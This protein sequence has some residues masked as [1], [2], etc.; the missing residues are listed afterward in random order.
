MLGAAA[1]LGSGAVAAPATALAEPTDYGY[2]GAVGTYTVPAGVTTIRIEATGGAGGNGGDSHT[3]EN[4]GEAGGKGGSGGTVSAYFSVT[5]GEQLSYYVGG[6]G[7]S[8]AASTGFGASAT[9]GEFGGGAGGT[10]NQSLSETSATG[11]GG[12]GGAATWVKTSSGTVLAV[13]GGGGGGGGGGQADTQVNGSAAFVQVYGGAGGAGGL[14]PA[15]G[16]STSYSDQY[17]LVQDGAVGGR[18]GANSDRSG[19]T[20]GAAV[21]AQGG[22]GGG[23]GGGYENCGV[24]LTGGGAPGA[25]GFRSDDRHAQ[26]GGAGGGGG[27]SCASPAATGVSYSTASQAPGDAGTVSF[28][29]PQATTTALTSSAPGGAQDF[30]PTFTAT[31]SPN[32][33]S[34]TVAF[35]MIDSAGTRTTLCGASPVGAGGLATCTPSGA[36]FTTIGDYGITAAYSG[37]AG[38]QTSTSSQLP[39][40]V[41]QL[42]ETDFV[43]PP[44]TL[45]RYQTGDFTVQVIGGEPGGRVTFSSA[46]IPSRV[47]YLDNS[48]HATTQLA[49]ATSGQRTVTASYAPVHAT[50]NTSAPSSATATV[51]VT[52]EIAGPHLEFVPDSPR[53]QFGQSQRI[54]VEKHTP[55]LGTD[56]VTDASDFV[57]MTMDGGSCVKSYVYVN[58]EPQSAFWTCTPSSIGPH[59]VT[60]TDKDKDYVCAGT[61]DC[62]EYYA[63]ASTTLTALGPAD[64]LRI[65]AAQSSVEVGEPD[66]VTAHWYDAGGDDLGP[67]TGVTYTVDPEGTCFATACIPEA[68]GKHTVT[69]TATLPG[70]GTVSARTTFGTLVHP[71]DSSP[72]PTSITID[73]PGAVS[74]GQAVTYVAHM[75]TDPRSHI[76]DVN[77]YWLVDG[78]QAQCEYLY[79]IAEDV[80]CELTIGSGGT[81]AISVVYPA[82]GD[83]AGSADTIFVPV[84]GPQVGIRVSPSTASTT[85]G[86][87]VTFTVDAV[88]AFGDVLGPATGATLSLPDGTGS[89]SG[90]ACTPTSAGS[91][92]VTAASSAGYTDT[93]TLNVSAGDLSYVTVTPS[94]STISAGAPQTYAVAGFD[95]FGNRVDA[96]APTL[97]IDGARASCQAATC[98]ATGSGEHTVTAALGGLHAFA[99]LTVQ[100]GPLNHLV[101]S[102]GTATVTAGG[103]QAYTAEGFDQFGNDLGPETGSAIFSLAGGSCTGDTCTAGLAGRQTVTASVGGASGTASLTVQPGP[104]DHL[105]VS[106]GT[107]TVT[108]GSS[109]AY[110]AE[111]FDAFGNSLGDETGSASFSISPDGWCT[112][113]ICT[114]N[115]DGQHTVS[116]AVG[117]ASGTAS[118]TVQPGA[119]GY[120]VASPG[121]GSMTA[122]DST[123]FS[124]EGLDVFGNDLGDKTGVASFSISPDGS[125]TGAACTATVAGDHTVTASVGGVSTSVPLAVTAAPLDHLVVKPGSGSMTAGDSATFSVEG[126]DVFGNDLGDKTGVAS[127]SISPD[128]SCTGATCT[129]TVAGDHTVTA[130]VGAVSNSVPL[131]VVPAPLDHLVMDP[132]S[133]TVTAGDSTSFSVEGFDVYDNDLGDQTSA[134][135]FAVTGGSC[136]GATCT[137]TAAGPQTVTA[138]V[139][140]VSTTA[141]LTVLHGPLAYLVVSPGT[142][143]VTAGDATTFSA[144]GFDVYGNSLGDETNAASF[145]VTGGSC[146]GATCTATVTGTYTVI[147]S[148]GEVSTSMPLTVTPGALDHLVVSPATTTVT[149][150]DATTFSVEG[151]DVFGNDLGDKT[152]AVS[153]SISPDGS[154]TGSTCTA[155][156]AGQHTVTA[157]IGAADAAAAIRPFARRT[158][159]IQGAVVATAQL[160][161]QAGPARHV[162]LLPGRA[163]IHP[164][165]WQAFTLQVT[166]AYGNPLAAP[167]RAA[168]TIAPSTP[169]PGSGARCSG[170]RCTAH[171]P[172]SYLVTA[173]YRGLIAQSRLALVA[174]SP[175]TPGRHDGN[176]NRGLGVDAAHTHRTGDL[177]ETGVPV[178]QL[179]LLGALLLG[180]GVVV[181]EAGRRQRR[182]V[183]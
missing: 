66:T 178:R 169:G 167:A 92:T 63:T 69:G 11:G 181:S 154:C 81:H 171:R 97:T 103:S 73:D 180:L 133:A 111:G 61:G 117:G 138:S 109:Q 6:G 27:A 35:T 150:G 136:A 52:D 129:A 115:R 25:G 43:S 44:S 83:R 80:H 40:Y 55:D 67:A 183:R 95:A 78:K 170:M 17:G 70:G 42:T 143:T 102:P 32:D 147:A 94:S 75:H 72:Y 87:P 49:F 146:A 5:P 174:A 120:L 172:G 29:V 28:S 7:Q 101:V 141:A 91:Q 128:G 60:A 177:A 176:Q 166:D 23:G 144:E 137:S 148:V 76:Y 3:S 134:A 90:L 50:G 175:V 34:G 79:Y 39:Y 68:D 58:G 155:T 110:T 4:I 123:R 107:A 131:I 164:G 13:A 19:G 153:F 108:A 84:L 36:V 56:Y 15:D 113:A 179:L 106:P 149:A 160:M 53:V 182:R 112:S 48:D 82:V 59:T 122:G 100:P 64:H 86:Q 9:G 18:G 20:G 116:A 168:L 105:A 54:T 22:G 26:I 45:E 125:C 8:A 2:T 118:L 14:N 33:G 96:G 41:G 47:A 85:A 140:T 74:P 89:C 10:G 24:T 126:F 104:L 37:S 51:T 162:Q 163:Q 135:S 132:G 88:D 161:V 156:V 77:P 152:D 21:D 99:S 71:A 159:A 62:V 124:V 119:L 46:G 98:T 38:Y 121:S 158:V 16:G 12:A 142:A 145:A 57:T 157:S 127:F 1:L 114:A 173:Q 31:V 30:A 130:T 165:D 65:Q 151:F 139:G 93:A